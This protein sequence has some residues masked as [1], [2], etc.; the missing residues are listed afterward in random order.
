MMKF[1]HLQHPQ[2]LYIVEKL[3]TSGFQRYNSRIPEV[4]MKKKVDYP[5]YRSATTITVFGLQERA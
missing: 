4:D 3:R 1:H 2:V 5:A